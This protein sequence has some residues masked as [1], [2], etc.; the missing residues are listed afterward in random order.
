MA[1]RDVVRGPMSLTR[2]AV[3]LIGLVALGLLSYLL[4]PS[5]WGAVVDLSLTTVVL[6]VA[7]WVPASRTTLRR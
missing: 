7:W 3:V 1:G 4:L 6:A 2:R 5:P